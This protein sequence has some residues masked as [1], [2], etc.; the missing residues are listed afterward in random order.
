MGRAG[1][2]CGQLWQ[3]ALDRLLMGIAVSEDDWALAAGDIAPLGVEGSDIIVAG[4]LADVL[5]HLAAIADEVERP[6][7]A[8]E[9]CATLLEVSG[10]LFTVE[11]AQQWQQDRL[12]QIIADIAD[13]ATVGDRASTVELTFA[14][15]RRLLAE[16]L[17]GAPRRPDFFRGGIT[18]SS[19][20]PLR[21]LPF[22][23]V[24]LL[25][26]DEDAIRTGREPTATTSRPW[27]LAS[28]TATPRAE[29]RQTLLEAVLAAGDHLVV[30]RTGHNILTNQ[31]VP[32]SV[33]FAELRDT[34][35]ADL[36]RRGAR[37]VHDAHRDR[38]SAPAVR[39]PLLRARRAR[40]GPWSFDATALDG[41]RA[42]G[43]VHGRGAAVPR[44]A[45][46][47][48]G[49]R[50]AGHHARGAAVVP[51]P[52]G[53]VLLRPAAPGPPA[54][55]G[56]RLS[57][58]LPISL[59]GLGGVVGGAA[60]DR[61]PAHG[62]TSV[63]WAAPRAGDRDAPGGRLRRSR[64]WPR[65]PGSSTRS[66]PTTTA[67]G[68]DPRHDDPQAIDLELADGT[69]IVGTVERH[70]GSEHPGPARLTFSKAQPKHHL[71]AWL[72]LMAL[73]AQDPEE[74]WRACTCAATPA[75]RNRT[76]WSS[77]RRR[78][79]SSGDRMRWPCST[80]WSTSTGGACASRSRCSPSCSRKLFDDKAV[81]T[82]WRDQM[83]Y[84]EGAEDSHVLAFGAL[85]LYELRALPALPH[86]PAGAAPGRARRFA[87]Y[88][89]TAVEGSA[90]V[91]DADP[92]GAGPSDG[93]SRASEA[94]PAETPAVVEAAR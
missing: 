18:F 19:L 39:R 59:G 78:R 91:R 10:R 83:G 68:V 60:P 75:G 23:V 27:H 92:S 47:R 6:A 73:V 42:R 52:P 77:S 45:A 35:T 56:R 82:D 26:L 74:S 93:D 66:S 80:W 61:G 17:H 38:P 4:R 8:A 46:R 20:T 70:C 86:D 67:L 51:Q 65:S 21:W 48:A 37:D 30:T 76:R 54:P 50:G 44:P 90:Q 15:L 33:P 43:A 31:D 49:G 63:E 29:L 7:P 41:A 69:R 64:R 16:R 72:D 5:A 94:G 14:D 9:W 71:S 1:R 79:R 89:W 2:L 55:R 40:D 24:C 13:G 88:L 25:G 32:E 84:A 22:R 53:E 62:R 12:R 36:R 3:A 34:I 87:D 85:E 57:D 28:A 58:H 81:A 11:S